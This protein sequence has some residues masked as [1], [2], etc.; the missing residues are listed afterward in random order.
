MIDATHLLLSYW[1]LVISGCV[2]KRVLENAAAR[3]GPQNQ[4]VQFKNLESYL[5]QNVYEASGIRKARTTALHPQ[6]DGMVVRMNRYL[7]KVVPYH[8]REGAGWLQL[9]LLT[10]CS[11]V[12]DTSTN[13]RMLNNVNT[14]IVIDATNRL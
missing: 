6:S 11:T 1:D 7:A 14:R 8:Q 12:H 13:R 10:Y 3:N 2:T 9:F 5:F 4:C